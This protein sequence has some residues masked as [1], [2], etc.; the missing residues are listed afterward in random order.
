LC[1]S[2]HNQHRSDHAQFSQLPATTQKE[3]PIV[4]SNGKKGFLDKHRLWF[5][6]ED[7]EV[8]SDPNLTVEA[9]I[10]QENNK[11]IEHL[12]QKNN[13]LVKGTGKAEVEALG[14]KIGKGIYDMAFG[15]G[16]ATCHDIAS[17]P[18]LR[19]NIKAGTLDRARFE[20]ILREG[21]NQMPKAMD[22]I[23]AAVMYFTDPRITVKD[24]GYS[25]TQALDLLWAYLSVK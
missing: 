25:E 4:L 21:K 1:V 14:T 17:N 12:L 24:L 18:Q 15:R 3:N 23:M 11:L 2:W 19:A 16:C 8:L 6:T 10:R 13:Q 20:T 7:G 22:A 9:Q 5:T